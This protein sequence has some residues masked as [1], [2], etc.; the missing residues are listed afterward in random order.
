MYVYTY[1][2]IYICI[3]TCIY[4]AVYVHIYIYIERERERCSPEGRGGLRRDRSPD[5]RG[6][7]D[8]AGVDEGGVL[9]Q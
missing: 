6:H 7:E 4:Y 1:I 9:N 5:L 3:H 8:E 2:Y